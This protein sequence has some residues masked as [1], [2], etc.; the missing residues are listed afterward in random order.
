M[1]VLVTNASNAK[2]IVITRSLGKQK[3]EVINTDS[4][5]FSA[6]FFSRYSKGKLLT[7][8]ALLSPDNYIDS[9]LNYVRNNDVNLLM[10]VNSMETLLISKNKEKFTPYT[11]V[12]FEDFHKMNKLHDKEKLAKIADELNIPIP[13]TY[14]ITNLDDI[15]KISLNINYPVVIKLK[16]ATSSLGV[17][18]AYSQNEFISKFKDTIS[19]FNLN[20]S[21]Y[22]IVQEYISGDGY[23]VSVLMNH[24]ELRALFTHKRLREYPITGGPS[25]L[26]ESVRHPAMENIAVKLLKHFEW[27]GLAMVEFKLNKYTNMPVLIEVN[28]RFWG[29]INQA[30]T[31]GVD[32]PVLLY[33]MV[34][35]GDIEPVLNYKTGVKTRFLMNDSRALLSQIKSSRDSCPLLLEALKIGIIN[36]DVISFKD[37]LPALLFT[38]SNVKQSLSRGIKRGF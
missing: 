25:T 30:I 37:P 27:H 35:D 3:I 29:S 17:S 11:N 38:Y 23:G 18:Y 36:D 5:K 15:E 19:T 14:S 32:F 9:I 21:E 24:G 31:S 16:N 20:S 7:P 28:P 13:K 2:G 33:K 34:I 26:R 6:C 12:P 22:P 10:P 1:S 8:S 4:E